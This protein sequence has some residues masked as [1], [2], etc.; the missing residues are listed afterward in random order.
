MRSIALIDPILGALKILQHNLKQ[1]GLP[2]VFRRCFDRCDGPTVAKKPMDD[3]A[4]DL[5]GIGAQFERPF[6]DLGSGLQAAFTDAGYL[7]QVTRNTMA[8]VGQEGDDG[9]LARIATVAD[10][11]VHKLDSSL[12]RMNGD[13]TMLGECS[14]HLGALLR[15]NGEIRKIAFFLRVIGLNIGIE[16]S[17]S[18]AG[19]TMFDV[20]GKDVVTLST[21]V[22]KTNE[23]LQADAEAAIAVQA[24]ACDAVQTG[25][26][27]IGRLAGTARQAVR[28][29]ADDVRHLM[30]CAVQTMTR[31]G[32][33]SKT[34]S[35]QVG[36]VVAAIQFHDNMSQRLAHAAAALQDCAGE[37]MASQAT[38]QAIV[39]LQE[40]QIRQVMSE[41]REV[42]QQ[43]A[44]A[45]TI[46]DGQIDQL[47]AALEKFSVEADD[48]PDKSR[49]EETKDAFSGLRGALHYLGRLL[50]RG[51]PLIGQVEATLAEAGRSAEQ[52][53]GHAHQVGQVSL[54]LHIIALNAIVKAAHMGEQGHSL[55]VLAQEVRR[56]SDQAGNIV[57][58]F[59][60]SVAMID[61]SIAAKATTGGQVSEPSAAQDEIFDN[62]QQGIAEIEGIAE[63]FQADTCEARRTADR[64]KARIAEIQG[65]LTF[66]D[67]LDRILGETCDRLATLKE[68]L[69][70]HAPDEEDLQ[71]ETARLAV[72]YTMDQERQVHFQA[73]QSETAQVAS[74]L[75]NVAQDNGAEDGMV[76]FEE[77]ATEEVTA[78]DDTQLSEASGD[79]AP[80][81]SPSSDK[82]A[83][84]D[85]N[86][87]LF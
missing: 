30:D 34:I 19:R 18:E 68:T 87:E 15:H 66:F 9:L 51:A 60:Q 73:R 57:Q 16:C 24:N 27:Q 33:H 1:R 64:L 69:A 11:A 46:I 35:D 76:F 20:V 42:Y 85:D 41:A 61:S 56:L 63:R 62:I 45:F 5:A 58:N 12:E 52:L 78:T 37:A 77:F 32:Q 2:S 44:S 17:R 6:L 71:A 38:V 47:M 59:Q 50:R 70:P 54:S 25:F 14:D 23:A 67:D 7:T 79:S 74:V 72:H 65:G 22:L 43:N 84:L 40:A 21:K 86:I 39:T 10:Q 13:V 48:T 83:D 55:E 29:T 75:P 28:A 31:A 4:D 80:L 36:R 26:A 81:F 8:C 49:R 53:S 3:L 82:T